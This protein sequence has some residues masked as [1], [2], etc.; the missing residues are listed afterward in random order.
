MTPDSA[1]RP[2]P[3]VIPPGTGDQHWQPQPANGW[4]E[5]L[6]SPTLH[7]GTAP[8]SAG[9]QELPPLGKIR[10]HAHPAHT[11]LFYILAGQALAILDQVIHAVSAGTFMLAP[12]HTRHGFINDGTEPVRFLWVLTP[13]GLEDFFVGIGRP[14]RAGLPDPTP[15]PRPETATAIELATVFEP[16]DPLPIPPWDT[17]PITDRSMLEPL[18]LCA[19]RG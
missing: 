14:K 5:V 17:S 15:Y 9:L 8:F 10:E 6:T 12:P 11:E 7:P 13:P 16:L 2:R 3:L 1:S 18:R 4:I 19:R